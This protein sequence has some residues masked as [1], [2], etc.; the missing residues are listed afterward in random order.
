[1]ISAGK[2]RCTMHEYRCPTTDCPYITM[3]HKVIITRK[4]QKKILPSLPTHR[5]RAFFREDI[6]NK[7]RDIFMT[8]EE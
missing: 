1:M 8:Y 3:N 2:N 6:K 4:T 7:L 5:Q